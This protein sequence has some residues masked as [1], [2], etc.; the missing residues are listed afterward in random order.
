MRCAA[1]VISMHVEVHL[2][3]LLQ[4]QTPEGLA[5]RVDVELLDG[6]S[7]LNLLSS[8]QIEIS[9]EHLLFVV[10]GRI[11]DVEREL[12]DGDVVH[13]IPALSGG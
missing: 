2:H 10:N 6:S 3:T 5:R 7:L 9:P 13:L 12:H 8:L 1:A 11:A 4:R